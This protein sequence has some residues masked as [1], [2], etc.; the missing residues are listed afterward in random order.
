[1]IVG[2]ELNR[3]QI[4][5]NYIELGEVELPEELSDEKLQSLDNAL[6][7]YK[8][9]LRI[10]NKNMITRKVK[11]AVNKLVY[12]SDEFNRPNFSD[13]ISR[14]VNYDYNYLSKIFS[15]IEGKTIEKYFIE[16]RIERV[17][18]ML[19]QEGASL[20][21]IAYKMLYSSVA[22]LSNQFKKVTGLTPYNYKQLSD[23]RV[24]KSTSM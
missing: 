24:N 13:F 21:E 22:H 3:L 15:E 6:R 14:Q 23:N 7:K 4:P 18:E 12:S 17:K 11:D 9:A 19:F 20:N 8:L 5:Y 2:E 1:M 16:Q 10:N